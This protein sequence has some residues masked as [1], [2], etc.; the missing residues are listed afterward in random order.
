MVTYITKGTKKRLWSRIR[1]GELTPGGLARAGLRGEVVFKT[2]L[3]EWMSSGVIE[4]NIPFR[5]K[6][7]CWDHKVRICLVYSK[8]WKVASVARRWWDGN[9]VFVEP[10]PGAKECGNC[11]LWCQCAFYFIVMGSHGGI[12]RKVFTRFHLHFKTTFT[13]VENRLERSKHWSDETWKEVH[14]N[15]VD[16]SSG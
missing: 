14:S 15:N 13:A 2:D 4:E 12:L 9:T 7:L 16:V 1:M 10:Y 6:V 3:I 11:R 5:D 8:N